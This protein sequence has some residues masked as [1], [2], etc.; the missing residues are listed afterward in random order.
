[1]GID[2][3]KSD[4][5]SPTLEAP[6]A[7]ATVAAATTPVAEPGKKCAN[8]EKN[9]DEGEIGPPAEPALPPPEEEGV[10]EAQGVV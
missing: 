5:I 7:P 1:M 9:N 2:R 6:A 10:G 4:S 8:E 3:N